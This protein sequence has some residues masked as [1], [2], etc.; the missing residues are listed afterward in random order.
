MPVAVVTG[1]SAG[2][3]RAIVRAFADAGY[4][5]ALLA[6]GQAGLDETALEVV[7]RGRR[8][9]AIPTDVADF[10]AVREAARRT[11]EELGEI[12]VWINNAMSTIF[13]P[14]KDLTAEQLHRAT[15]V[16]Y[17]G[18]VHGTMAALEHMRP[19]D[20]GRIISVGSAL[21][22]RSI[23]LQA[24]YC[25]A[26]FATRGFLEALRCELIHDRS[27]VALTEVHMPGVNTPQFDWC[28]NH[29][30]FRPQPVAPIYQPE[31]CAKAVLKVARATTPPRHKVV[32]SWNWLLVHGNKVMPGIFDH[33][34]ART[35]VDG[36]QTDEEAGD[37]PW[38][39]FEPVDDRPERTRAARGRFDDMTGG[40]RNK[41]FLV[42][43]PKVA[44]DLGA[45]IIDRA[46]V[47]LSPR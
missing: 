25:G 44:T 7:S 1:A 16:T 11:E 46:R 17:Y 28:R 22:Y 43:L 5:V 27:N 30:P 40:V 6:R 47:S 41:K 14:V 8:A 10:E 12:D 26:K 39:L 38:N 9:L 29:L 36:Q 19:R 13:S 37:G 15:A 24:A 42:T 20:R 21:A 2:I 18:Q 32:G 45:S 23:P 4:D 3:G 31:V 34:A 35:A 33:Y